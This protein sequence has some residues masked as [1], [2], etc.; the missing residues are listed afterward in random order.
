MKIKSLL[1]I[2]LCSTTLAATAQHK[3]G[4]LDS[5]SFLKSLPEVAEIQ[6]TID[7][8]TSKIE[9]QL[10]VLQEDFTKMQQDFEAASKTLPQDELQEKANELQETYQKI[11][12]FIQMSRQQL[13]AKSQ[14]LYA[15]LLQKVRNAVVEVGDENGFTYI[16][17][18]Q[19][20]ALFTSTQSV[21][22]A[23]LVS[24]KLKSNSK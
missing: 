20:S 5:E 15:P 6:K 14:E 8:E 22:V 10:T 16:F 11:Q 18:K 24:A 12:N 1:T 19:G 13:Q 21:D 23:P 2:L 9:S 3:F 17:E 7:D 4:H